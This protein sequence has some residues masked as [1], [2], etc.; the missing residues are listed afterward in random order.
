[1]FGKK[2]HK[3]AQHGDE[4]RIYISPIMFVMALYFVAVG[5]AYE[6]CCSLAAVLLHECAHARVAKKLGYELNVI[7]L[8]PYGAALCGD[9]QLKP[10]D[11]V[12]IALAGPVFNLLIAVVIAAVWWLLPSS[13]MFTQAFCYGNVYIGLFNM[14]PV[15]PLDGGRVMLGV[16]SKKLKRKTACRVMRIVSV[17]CGLT[18]IALFALSAVSSLNLCLLSVGLFMTV[19][20]FIPDGKVKYRALFAAGNRVERIKTPLEVRRYAV[21]THSELSGVLSVLDPDKYSEFTVVDDDMHERGGFTE[22]Q[23]I[24]AVKQYGYSESVGKALNFN[25]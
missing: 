23:L 13:Y 11:E 3:P 18:A 16:L 1:M 17:A 15:Y 4:M 2:S 21:S 12:V 14:L 25:D 6:F 19:S 24:D 10:K 5:M 20:A 7:K 8:M 9:V 22:T